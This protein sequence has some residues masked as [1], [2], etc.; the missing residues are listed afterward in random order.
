[1]LILFPSFSVLLGCLY[2]NQCVLPFSSIFSILL[3]CTEQMAEWWPAVWQVKPESRCHQLSEGCGRSNRCNNSLKF[4][5]WMQISA[6][7]QIF[8]ICQCS[9]IGKSLFYIST[10]FPEN[11]LL[12]L[13]FPHS[14]RNRSI[15]Q[16]FIIIIIFNIETCSTVYCSS[17]TRV[18]VL[19]F[20]LWSVVVFVFKIISKQM[21]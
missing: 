19:N 11:V 12:G 3:Q 15:Q 6:L 17:S 13:F 20:S 1:M 14:Q 18:K 21:Q 7:E 8:G 5:F 9:F 2:H 10:S 4:Y 16:I